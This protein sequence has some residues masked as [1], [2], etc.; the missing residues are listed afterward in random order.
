VPHG[1]ECGTVEKRRP[2][3]R[4]ILARTTVCGEES[5]FTMPLHQTTTVNS[6]SASVT[7]TPMHAGYIAETSDHM[8]RT[9]QMGDPQ[10]ELP[11]DTPGMIEPNKQMCGQYA[12]P[13]WR[14]GTGSVW[15]HSSNQSMGAPLQCSGDALPVSGLQPNVSHYNNGVQYASPS[16]TMLD[17]TTP[18][19][20]IPYS[21]E[22]N[23]GT[24]ALQVPQNQYWQQEG[25]VP[26]SDFENWDRWIP[27][28]L[29]NL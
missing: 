21:L 9:H 15:P 8:P 23:K 11:E 25:P 24:E 17:A 2:T 13:H 26:L 6:D 19:E 5:D 20:A 22:A 4:Q 12:L 29:D 18:N 27:T 16:N 14:P 7:G 28:V 10:H 3:N 1:D